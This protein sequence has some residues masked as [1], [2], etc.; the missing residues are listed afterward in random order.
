MGAELP[1]VIFR[2]TDAGVRI[3]LSGVDGD[4]SECSPGQTWRPAVAHCDQCDRAL[5]VFVGD[6]SVAG[7]D[8]DQLERVCADALATHQM[9]CD[10]V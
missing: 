4:D 5:L 1:V 7:I 3:S 6:L 8:R 9:E 10:A 2:S